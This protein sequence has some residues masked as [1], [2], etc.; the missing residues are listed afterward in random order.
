MEKLPIFAKATP[1]ELLDTSR[2]KK[3]MG[4]TVHLYGLHA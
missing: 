4:L 3:N 2:I 1:S